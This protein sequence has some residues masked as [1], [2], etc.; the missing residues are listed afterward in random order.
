LSLRVANNGRVYAVWSA[1]LK[2]GS[3]TIP[4]I[5]V[6]PSRAI[7]PDG[8]FGGSET[9]TIRYRGFSER[10]R[11]SFSGQFLADGAKGTLRARMQWRDGKRHYAPCVSGQQTWAARAT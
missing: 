1:T 4:M 8:S 11:V 2:C 5:D 10:Y 3:A 6:T 7:R 9:Y